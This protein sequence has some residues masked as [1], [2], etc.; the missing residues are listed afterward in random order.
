MNIIIQCAASKRPNAGMLR[1]ATGR[2]VMFVAE[3]QLAPRGGELLYAR[4]DDMADDR[5]TWRDVLLQANQEP[6]DNPFGLLAA[7]DLYENPAYRRLAQR[8]GM[9]RLFILSAGWGLIRTNFLTPAYD[10]TFSSSAE[11]FKRR[12][13]GAPYRDFNMLPVNSDEPVLFLGGKDYLPLFDRLTASI[14]GQRIVLYNSNIAP[15]LPKAF[16]QRFVTTTRTNWHYE[17]A[18]ALIDGRIRLPV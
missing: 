11:P 1:S 12:G 4:P 15:R 17:C 8:F 2:T 6:A 18:Q 5:R 9:D 14:P 7:M 3:P 16:L 10:I 13:K